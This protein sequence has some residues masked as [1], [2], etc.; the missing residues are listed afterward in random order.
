[1]SEPRSAEAG[2]IASSRDDAWYEVQGLRSLNR[3]LISL[4][5]QPAIWTGQMPAGVINTL[6]E[7]LSSMLRVDLAY[8]RVT[9]PGEAAIEAAS[10]SACHEIAQRASGI[11]A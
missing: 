5:A 1:M 10:A 8:A 6:V 2:K 3:D 4:L 7:V 9:R 11:G